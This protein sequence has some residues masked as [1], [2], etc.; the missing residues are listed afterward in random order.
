MAASPKTVAITF[1]FASCLA[2][3]A[4]PQQ[5]DTRTVAAE[6]RFEEVEGTVDVR[7]AAAG[8]Q[9]ALVGE[10]RFGFAGVIEAAVF[11]GGGFLQRELAGCESAGARGDDHRARVVRGQVG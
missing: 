8:D 5:A 1:S 10:E 3:D 6:G 2:N 7:I 11:Q 9:H 4:T